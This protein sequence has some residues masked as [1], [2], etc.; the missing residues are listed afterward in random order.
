MK[1]TDCRDSAV[2]NWASQS[3]VHDDRIDLMAQASTFWV[4]AMAQDSDKE[5]GSG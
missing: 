4:K 5:D 2:L 3:L 1:S